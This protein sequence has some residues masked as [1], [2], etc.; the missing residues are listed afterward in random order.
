GFVAHGGDDHPDA[1]LV[2]GLLHPVQDLHRPGVVQVLEDQV[3]EPHTAAA[4]GASW[5][6]LVLFEEL[7]DLASGFGGHVEVAV[8][9]L[10]DG[11]NRD[12]GL[13]GHL[14]QGGTSSGHGPPRERRTRLRDHP[15]PKPFGEF[16][17]V[18]DGVLCFC[19]VD[20]TLPYWSFAERCDLCYS[21]ETPRGL[22]EI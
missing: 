4:G 13:T 20:R 18:A 8:D 5:P 3:D 7:F 15:S 6:V 2:G 17:G 22:T 16:S 11:G 12:T 21:T 14:G 10:G 19:V 1:L 9:H